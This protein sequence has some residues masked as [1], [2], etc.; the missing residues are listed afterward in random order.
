MIDKIK[1]INNIISEEDASFL[2]QWMDKNSDRF[3]TYEEEGNPLRLVLRFGLDYVYEASNE[4]MAMIPDI[5]H[6]IKRLN[7]NICKE[8]KLAYKNEKDLYVTSLHIGKQLPG[9]RVDTH[10]DADPNNNGHFKYSC[11]VYLN[12]IKNGGDLFFTKLNHAYH[13][14]ALQAAVFPSQGDEYEH[15]VSSI[16]EN[17]YNLPIWITE[18]P[19]MEIKYS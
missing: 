19:A 14:Q 13:P 8:I 4:T 12:E 10:V 16:G 7:D 15:E 9:S 18:D 17:R 2:M 11:V 6:I 3:D 1:I 5:H